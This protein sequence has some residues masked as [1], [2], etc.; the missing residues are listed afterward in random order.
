MCLIQCPF[1]NPP[2]ENPQNF[3]MA[4]ANKYTN[5]EYFGEQRLWRSP[6]PQDQLRHKGT[7]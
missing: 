5:L 3:A 6:S 7:S 2:Q 4:F 1:S